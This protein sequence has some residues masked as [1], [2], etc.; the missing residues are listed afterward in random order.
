VS[1]ARRELLTGLSSYA[2][3][4]QTSMPITATPTFARQSHQA[5][6]LRRRASANI[7][8]RPVEQHPSSDVTV[9]FRPLMAIPGPGLPASARKTSARK[10]RATAPTEFS[11]D[12]APAARGL[13]ALHALRAAPVAFAPPPKVTDAA[14]A[15]FHRYL[16]R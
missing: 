14:L 13:S 4:P 8:D 6:T 16:I 3:Y 12:L 10:W 1:A 7:G 2:K 11:H 5:R 9:V 15:A